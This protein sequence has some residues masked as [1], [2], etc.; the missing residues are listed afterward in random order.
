MFPS[1]ALTIGQRSLFGS[2]E[3]SYDAEFVESSRFDLDERTWIDHAPGWLTGA[4][5]LFDV[6]FDDLVDDVWCDEFLVVG[7]AVDEDSTPLNHWEI[8]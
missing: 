1:P 2:L 5:R 3:P 6:I 7:I 8:T 4:D